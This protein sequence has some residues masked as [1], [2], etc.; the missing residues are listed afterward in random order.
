MN[1]QTNKPPM[2]ILIVD[3]HLIVVEGLKSLLEQTSLFRVCG[4]ASGTVEGLQKIEELNPEIII[5]DLCLKQGHGLEFIKDVHIRYPE[6]PMIVLS[7]LDEK[8]YAERTLR[9]G[10]KGYIMKDQVFDT[11]VDA[12]QKVGHGEK[13]VSPAVKEL[14]VDKL[15]CHQ[16]KDKLDQ[17]SDKELIVLNY[18]RSGLRPRHI[19]ER[20]SISVRTV[21][22]YYKRIQKKLNLHNIQDIIH[23]TSN[24]M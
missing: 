24:T 11:I 23:Y 1:M 4:S 21:D 20:M 22:T 3:D 14:L 5:I 13:Y 12:L 7:M 8:I 18:I 19:S 9:A 2:D 17:L 6:I 10:A 16:E 15:Y